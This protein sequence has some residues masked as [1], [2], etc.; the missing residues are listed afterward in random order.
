MDQLFQY[1]GGGCRTKS[2]DKTDNKDEMLL[3]DALFP[4]L[5]AHFIILL[6]KAQVGRGEKTAADDVETAAISSGTANR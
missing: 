1:Y 4:P 3:L 6:G 5:I 2:H